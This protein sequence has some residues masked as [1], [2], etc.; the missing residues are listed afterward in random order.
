MWVVVVGE[1]TRPAACNILQPLPPHSKAAGGP[2]H[3]PPLTLAQSANVGSSGRVMGVSIVMLTSGSWTCFFCIGM[4]VG[5]CVCGV[6]K[7][8]A[9]ARFKVSGGRALSAFPGACLHLSE[10]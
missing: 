5:V 9:D 10:Y 6:C 8:S 3:P 1:G 4:C 2:A 7:L